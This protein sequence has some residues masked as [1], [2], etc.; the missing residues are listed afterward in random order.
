MEHLSNGQLLDML[1]GRG[2]QPEA[3]EGHLAECASCRQRLASLRETWDVLG[4]WSVEERA[5]DLT[6][7]IMREAQGVRSVYLWQPR[8]VVRI[9]AS[10]A[11]GI[12][13][14]GFLGRPGPVSVSDEQA[15]EAMYLDALAL[16]SS[17]GWASPLLGET[18]GD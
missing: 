12:G 2:S 15:A 18:G 17:T 4:E 14:G 11:I 7:R 3:V 16:Q 6:G 10:I 13:L 5:T 1:S 9:A 8:A